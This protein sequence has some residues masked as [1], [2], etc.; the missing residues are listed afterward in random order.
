MFNPKHNLLEQQLAESGLEMSIIINP[1]TVFGAANLG[2]AAFGMFS[3]NRQAD[4]NLDFSKKQAKIQSKLAK[5]QAKATNEYFDFIE[6]IEEAN[7][8]EEMDYLHKDAVQFWKDGRRI[9]NFEHANRLR[10]YN[11]DQFISAVNIGLNE[12]AESQA[13]DA[14]IGNLND[15]YISNQLDRGANFDALKRVLF[16]S[17]IAQGRAEL[18]L[19]Q[20]KVQGQTS[21]LA[22]QLSL[23]RSLFE[24]DQA[25]HQNLLGLQRSLFEGKTAEAQQGI[26]LAGIENRQKFGQQAIQ[27]T[28]DALMERN[29]MQKETEAINALLAEGTAQLGQAGRS[30]QKGQQSIKVAMFRAMRALDSELSGRYKQA[31][32]Q[33]AELNADTNLQRQAVGVEQNRIKQMM[34]FAQAGYDITQAGIEAQKGFAQAGF[35]LEGLRIGAQMGFAQQGFDL[36]NARIN[37][38]IEF[39]QNEYDTNNMVLDANLNSAIEA[40]ERNIADIKLRRTISDINVFE[41]MM[42]PPEKL[43][44]RSKPIKP[45]ERTFIPRQRMVV[46]ETTDYNREESKIEKILQDKGYEVVRGG[47]GNQIQD[48]V[49]PEATPYLDEDGNVKKEYKVSYGRGGVKIYTNKKTGQTYEA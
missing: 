5:E 43:P 15:T 3:A 2:L 39:A 8:K 6:P 23:N 37:G 9:H 40:A 24:S 49:G 38:A 20:A 11:K 12:L 34:G 17:G 45:P 32:I 44:Y 35:D 14:E 29:A 26:R 27:Q 31:G 33:L 7:Y 16:D 30:T 47:R 13:I 4:R 42:L 28:V 48:I 36:D 22:N 25:S 18:N 41:S 21:N 10:E 1:A 19:S 46:P